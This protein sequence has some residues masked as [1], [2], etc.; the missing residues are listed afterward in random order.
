MAIE[1]IRPADRTAWLAARRQ[2][3]TASVAG[4]LLGVHPYETAYGL[5]ATKTGRVPDIDEDSPVLRRGR[6]LEPAA[7]EMLREER[8]EWTIDYRRDNAYWRDTQA[9]LGATPDAFATRPDA[10]GQ[11]VVQVKT[12]SEDKF[13]REW[14]DPETGE[15][16]LPLFIAV[17]AIIEAD[18][19]GAVWACVAPMVI[20]YGVDMQPID[21]PVHLGIRRRVR[22]AVADFWRM[23]EAGVE[24]PI[25]WMRDGA[26]VAAVYRETQPDRRDLTNVDGLDEMVGRLAAAKAAQHEAATTVDRLRPML[27]RTMGAA[28]A[29]FTANWN[30]SAKATLRASENGAVKSRAVRI[31]PRENPNADHF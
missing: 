23:A 22:A 28:E 15:I 26:T 1:I 14:I 10:Y 4:A 11:G 29:G 17:Q 24:P 18:L 27:L 21:V 9:R 6:L 3:V 31:T 20:G 12:V 2:D 13:R 19:T 7:I 16:T 5:W 30:I 8:P 25:D